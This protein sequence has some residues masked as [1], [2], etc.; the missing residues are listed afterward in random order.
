MLLFLCLAKTRA[1]ETFS[2]HALWW[3]NISQLHR[4]NL[5]FL[6]V[7]IQK[8]SL[9]LIYKHIY[10]VNAIKLSKS[11]WKNNLQNRSC[12]LDFPNISSLDDDLIEFSYSL[13][14]ILSSFKRLYV[15]PSFS[16]ETINS[17]KKQGKRREVFVLFTLQNSQK[18]LRKT[19]K[20]NVSK[21]QSSSL[22]IDRIKTLKINDL[23]SKSN[24]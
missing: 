4:M 7:A 10:I 14:N 13:F 6:A 16:T 5:T 21:V 9:I 2:S 3:L 12:K 8:Q 22:F 23:N 17:I 11:C 1:E 19:L 18:D 15:L 24:P 20:N